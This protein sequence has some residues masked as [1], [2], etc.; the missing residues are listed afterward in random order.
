MEDFSERG[1]S[2]L[3][4]F[5]VYIKNP[6]LNEVSNQDTLAVARETSQ[7]WLANYNKNKPLF[8]ALENFTS[9][10]LVIK[11]VASGV[12]DIVH[13]TAQLT[14]VAEGN[15]SLKQE[16]IAALAKIK[17]GIK[18]ISDKV[19]GK[20]PSKPVNNPAMGEADDFYNKVE[21]GNEFSSL[22]RTMTDIETRDW[23]EGKLDNIDIVVQEMR[24]QGRSSK[25]IFE[26]TTKMRNETKLQAREFMKNQELANSLP[27]PKTPSEVLNRYDNDYEKAIEAARRTNAKVNKSINE[28]RSK[29]EE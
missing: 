15:S 25:D 24:L 6:E 29:G 9:G 21:N 26:A 18:S 13:A 10:S 20:V 14:D 5:S 7:E 3:I 22:H 23:Y 11:L 17:D 28:R 19:V 2:A 12:T 4:D 1:V 16:A 8:D 27:P